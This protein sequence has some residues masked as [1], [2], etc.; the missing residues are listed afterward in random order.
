MFCALK[1]ILTRFPVFRRMSA[2]KTPRLAVFHARACDAPP[3]TER[4]APES[5]ALE[6][7][8]PAPGTLSSASQKS[9]TSSSHAF[10]EAPRR[11]SRAGFD[12]P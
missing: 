11:A 8:R 1:R 6:E 12:L 2:E 3:D 9:R 5:F 4:E 7:K 10:P